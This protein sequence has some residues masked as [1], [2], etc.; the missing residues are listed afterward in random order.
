MKKAFFGYPLTVIYLLVLFS[1]TGCRDLTVVER[2]YQRLLISDFSAPLR[3]SLPPYEGTPTSLTLLI[4]GTISKPVIITVDQLG[5]S[6][7][8]YAIR[9]DT[10]M[11]GTYTDQRF[12]G[13]H[14]SNQAIEMIVTGADS[15]VGNLTIEWYRQ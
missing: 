9:R 4:N 14:Y 5:G 3:T 1:L 15:A 10:L 8:R 2:S 11:A 7:G 6:Q 13:D 12:R